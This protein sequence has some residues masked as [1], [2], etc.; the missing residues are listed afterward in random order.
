MKNIATL[1]DG[2]FLS[3]GG[4]GKVVVMLYLPGPLCSR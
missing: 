3:E 1:I 4:G 2:E